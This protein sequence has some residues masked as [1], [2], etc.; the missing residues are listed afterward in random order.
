MQLHSRTV[1]LIVA[2]FLVGAVT[3]LAGSTAHTSERNPQTLMTL[4]L[5]QEASE[6]LPSFKKQL[7][8][9]G[10]ADVFPPKGVEIVS[11]RGSLELGHVITLRLPTYKIPEVRE[12]VDNRDWG[13]IQ[14]K[15]YT[16]YD[17]EPFWQDMGGEMN[18]TGRECDE[19]R[20][21]A[22]RMLI[23]P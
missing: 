9:N 20:A 1:G 2:L 3:T 8:E 13:S 15:L 17:F 12:V 11:W 22:K 6:S 4:V 19:Y 10:F 7:R 5:H 18:K 21:S 14:P 16:S 23:A